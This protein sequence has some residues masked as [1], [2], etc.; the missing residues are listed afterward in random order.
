M[1]QPASTLTVDNAKAALEAGLRAIEAGQ[2]DIDLSQ[3]TVV[4]SSAV[5]TLL[6]WKRA[7]SARGAS[8]TFRSLPPNLLS[9][10]EL[11]GVAD[12]LHPR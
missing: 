3:L 11:Y 9:L 7:A 4:D 12:L 2:S 1:F 8:V 6:A 10:V 5:A